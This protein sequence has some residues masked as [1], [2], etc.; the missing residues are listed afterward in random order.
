[1]SK[2]LLFAASIF[3]LSMLS[4][5]QNDQTSLSQL[6]VDLNEWEGQI[7]GNENVILVFAPLLAI[8][9]QMSGGNADA[10]QR[11]LSLITD[12][13][14]LP[15]KFVGSSGRT[16]YA[17]Y[18]TILGNRAPEQWILNADQ[19]HQLKHA[20]HILLRRYCI[21]A[22]LYWFLNHEAPPRED[23]RQ[24]KRYLMY[25]RDYARLQ[26]ELS[27]A[28]D[29][30]KRAQLQ[31]QL[32]KLAEEWKK[33]GD[34]DRVELALSQ[35][36]AVQASSP[37][38][39]WASVT[40]QFLANVRTIGGE[41]IPISGVDPSTQSWASPAGWQQWSL[42]Q[43]S[44][45][46]KAVA[47]TRK[48]MTLDVLTV[49]RWSWTSGLYE[50]QKVVVSDGKGI[51]SNLAAR[52]LMPLLPVSLILAKNVVSSGRVISSDSPVILGLRCKVLP[53]L[54]Q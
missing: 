3:A 51:A 27:R 8:D 44:A 12:A 35:Y 49:H 20:E 9:P 13:V 47:I 28:S 29:N 6:Q 54:P 11:A 5:G 33:K 10:A 23:S 14:P 19:R 15:A 22:R 45:Q 34:K 39:F 21:F 24:Y 16:T 7:H 32:D 25:A 1:M 48:W 26:T 17:V 31:S 2:R 40:N 43:S 38:V 42:K 53:K 41:S 4:W 52:E 37:E 18:A 46:I 30:G 50:Q 36:R